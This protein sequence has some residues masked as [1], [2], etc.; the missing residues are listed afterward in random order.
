MDLRALG[1]L[2]SALGGVFSAKA[3]ATAGQVQGLLLGEDLTER[4]QRRKMAEE[5]HQLQ[6]EL[7]RAQEQRRQELFP[8]EKEAL[9]TQVELGKLN[10]EDTRLWTLFRQGVAPSQISDPV[11]RARYEPFFNY[12]MAVR[13]LE[14]VQT[15]ED[16]DTVLKQVP[17]EFRPSLEIMGRTQLFANQSRRQMIERQL[18][19]LDL[20]L[21]QGEFQLRTAK[22]NTA[23]NLI[24]NNINAEGMDWDKRTPQQKIEA[25]KKWIAQAGLS[26]V[27]SEDFANMFQRVKSTD[28]RQF[29]LYRL[30][31][32][33][34]Q[35]MQRE[36]MAQQ[37]A[38]NLNLQD[39]AWWGNLVA[40]ALQGGI[41]GQGGVAPVGFSTPPPIEVFKNTYDNSGSN[42][43]LSGLEKYLK[44]PM[45]ISVPR[46]VGQ[47]VVLVPLSVL[48][49]EVSEIYKRLARPDATLSAE[50]INTL[51]AFDAG[52]H[53][54]YALK[55]NMD[56]DWNTA[57]AIATQR[58][59]ATLKSNRAYMANREH[60]GRIL[61]DWERAWAR[62]SQQ[63]MEATSPTQSG[64]QSPNM[65]RGA[66]GGQGIPPASAPAP[67]S[68]AQGGYTS[69][70]RRQRN[71]SQTDRQ[72]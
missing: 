12:Q 56:L 2:L 26:D 16:L 58:V 4:R 51:I 48:Q 65:L 6:T 72:P 69:N 1:A 3:G 19:G 70:A 61:D 55:D 62:M 18:Q 37:Y 68:G 21:A 45:N 49:M 9:A 20:N 11:L 23:L 38:Y 30:Q 27:V 41:G 33:L 54:A 31:A 28:A 50:D 8:F 32:E 43:N 46:R 71:S 66:I 22:L 63:Q 24:I 44:I 34:Q 39:R 57:F 29:A 5:A 52:L 53:R 10:L 7:A 47:Q 14:A 15:Q 67:R 36:L 25:V 64:G 17:E 59:L 60:Y 42:L 40:G 35:K 13:N